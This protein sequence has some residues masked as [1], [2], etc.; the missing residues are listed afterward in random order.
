MKS[1]ISTVSRF[2]YLNAYAL[3]LLLGG[4][5]F[6]IIP[7]FDN[8]VW[9]IVVKV[10]VGA[11]CLKGAFSILSGWNDKKRKYEVLMTRN[12]ETLRPDTFKEYM[13]APCGRLLTR[14]VL[15]DLGQADQYKMLWKMYHIPYWK[16]LKNECKPKK[17]VVYVNSDFVKKKDENNLTD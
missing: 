11:V 7:L 6:A 8:A 1:P 3:L 16:H 9:V 2:I 14:V 10:V 4:A 5:G 17:T 15:K 13:E 12:R